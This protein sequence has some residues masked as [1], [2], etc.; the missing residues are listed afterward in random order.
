MDLVVDTNIIIAAILKRGATRNLIFSSFLNLHAPEHISYEIAK[1]HQEL[2]EKAGMD[3][4]SFDAALSVVLSQIDVISKSA[5]SSK[6]AEAAGIC[7]QHPEDTPFVALSL[8]LRIPVWTHDKAFSRHKEI[9]TISTEE[10]L[11]ILISE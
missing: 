5:F 8:H 3:S 1:Y 9:K 7:S 4:D 2:M 11:R 6:L 10:L